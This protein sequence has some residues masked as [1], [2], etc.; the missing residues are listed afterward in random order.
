MFWNNYK[1]VFTYPPVF[2]LLYVYKKNKQLSF[3]SD[4]YELLRVET[5]SK[6]TRSKHLRTENLTISTITTFCF[7]HLRESQ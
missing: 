2:S 5:P 7:V 3:S 1:L 4:W 6:K